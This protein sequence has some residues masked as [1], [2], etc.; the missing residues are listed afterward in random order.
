M[1]E[2]FRTLEAVEG[3]PVLGMAADA[4]VCLRDL[5]D[6]HA[7]HD[8]TMPQRLKIHKQ[9]GEWAADTG[10]AGS[11]ARDHPEDPLSWTEWADSIRRAEGVEASRRVLSQAM[12]VHSRAPSVVYHLACCNCVLGETGTA[13]RLLEIAIALD[14]GLE[15]V[16]VVDSDL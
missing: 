14:P 13:G 5:P 12:C 15:A 16:A 4:L 10:I 6:E 9:M 8:L 3:S 7:S 1:S 11:S 2:L